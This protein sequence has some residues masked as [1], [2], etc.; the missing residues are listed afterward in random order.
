MAIKLENKTN[1]TAPDVTYPYGNIKNDTG[2]GD[3]TPVNV[4]VYADFHQFFARMAALAGITYN[5]LPDNSTNGYQYYDALLSLIQSN[6]TTANAVT[7]TNTV[8]LTV[9]PFTQNRHNLEYANIA[10]G[11]VPLKTFTYDFTNAVVGK[12]VRLHY[13]AQTGSTFILDFPL[14]TANGYTTLVSPGGT[15]SSTS[16]TTR[17]QVGVTSSVGRVVV[18]F[19][20]LGIEPTTNAKLVSVKIAIA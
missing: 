19:T 18:E 8:G 7:V 16:T 3:G 1:V 17:A 14:S 6:I 13:G 9:I 4:Q 5:N 15:V 2:A 11:S 20:Y 10:S 12:V